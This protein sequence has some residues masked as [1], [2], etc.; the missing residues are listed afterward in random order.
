MTQELQLTPQH[1]EMLEK[2]LPT[3][4]DAQKRKTLELLKSYKKQ[5]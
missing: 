5:R 2:A 3:M 1:I 4:G